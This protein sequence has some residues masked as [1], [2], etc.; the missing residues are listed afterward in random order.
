MLEA[1]NLCLARLW[2]GVS[3]A[4]RGGE[5]LLITGENG[6][7][8]TSLVEVLCGLAEPDG[9]AVLWRRQNI[10]RAAEEYRADLIYVGHKN[11]VKSECTALENL[12]FAAA[13]HCG[14]AALPPESA[15]QKIGLAEIRKPCGQLSAGQ[16]R[17]A[18]LARLLANRA[19][20]WILDEPLAALDDSAR[21][22]FGGIAAAHLAGGGGIAMAT[23]QTPEHPPAAHVLRLGRAN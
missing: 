9:G 18:A 16:N 1:K 15:L 12:S 13:L 10:R 23:H 8:K 21:E 19:R 3:F 2:G 20:L 11:G 22:I 14:P 4:L 5:M 7:G 6:A 17:R